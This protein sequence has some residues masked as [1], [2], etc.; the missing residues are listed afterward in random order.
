M[1]WACFSGDHRRSGLIPFFGDDRGN[2]GRNGVNRFTIY[3]LYQ[4]ILP[5]LIQPV[6]RE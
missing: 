4:R 5:T 3:D 1:F 2:G 6:P